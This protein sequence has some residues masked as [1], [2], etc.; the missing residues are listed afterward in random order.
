MAKH[1]LMAGGAN[2]EAS[3]VT[4]DVVGQI[5][6]K[7]VCAPTPAHAPRRAHAGRAPQRSTA[8]DGACLIHA[9]QVVADTGPRESHSVL[10]RRLAATATRACLCV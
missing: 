8:A 3:C 1:M 6:R 10:T 4:Y 2:I 7:T 9:S 5:V